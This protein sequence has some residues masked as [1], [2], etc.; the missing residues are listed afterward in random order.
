MYDSTAMNSSTHTHSHFMWTMPY[1]LPTGQILAPSISQRDLNCEMPQRPPSIAVPVVVSPHEW[2]GPPTSVAAL[3]VGTN[4]LT[5]ELAS[6]ALPTLNSSEMQSPS[7]QTPRDLPPLPPLCLGVP[8]TSKGSRLCNA[9]TAP[10]E[11][12]IT[13]LSKQECQPIEMPTST[14]STCSAALI[15]LQGNQPPKEVPGLAPREEQQEKK[16]TVTACWHQQN[17][18]GWR[19]YGR[20]L[21]AKGRGSPFK[22]QEAV[23]MYYKCAES[24]CNAR[25]AVMIPGNLDNLRKVLRGLE[26]PGE[27]I[28]KAIGNHNHELSN[29]V[30]QEVSFKG[31]KKQRWPASKRKLKETETTI[32]KVENC[33]AATLVGGPTHS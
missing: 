25:E 10:S 33:S 19:K 2:F 22:D 24:G 16:T 32:S 23:A 5:D 9:E 27:I 12:R 1:T 31:T 14:E 3:L 20:K 4:E 17:R 8:G 13:L 30:H 26:E 18:W 29:C 28:V 21:L 15:E 7:L 11:P 6:K